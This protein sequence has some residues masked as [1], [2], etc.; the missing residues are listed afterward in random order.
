MGGVFWGV[1]RILHLQNKIK[2]CKHVRAWCRIHLFYFIF[3]FSMLLNCN[4]IVRLFTK[5]LNNLLKNLI[6]YLRI[7]PLYKA[8]I[9]F[10]SIHHLFKAFFVIQICYGGVRFHILY[11]TVQYVRYFCL[12]PAEKGPDLIL[13]PEHWG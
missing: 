7:Y 10:K 8:F 13:N 4:I 2:M 6:E 5:N 1:L 3:K 9:F 12:D 11:C